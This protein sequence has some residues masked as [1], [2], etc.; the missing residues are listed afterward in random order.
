MDGVIT[1]KTSTRPL[2]A[3]VLAL[4][5]LG[6]CIES[7]RDKWVRRGARPAGAEQLRK[8]VRGNTLEGYVQELKGF[9]AYMAPDGRSSVIVSGVKDVGAWR[10]R[11]DGQLCVRYRNW[12]D[13][14]EQCA[15]YHTRDTRLR[16]FDADGKEQLG[17]RVLEGNPKDLNVEPDLV[18]ARKRGFKRMTAGEL[19]MQV[20]GNTLQGT[21]EIL[22][23]LHMLMHYGRD[24]TVLGSV[25]PQRDEGT[26]E[27]RDNGDLCATFQRW[28]DGRE[29]CGPLWVLGEE[30]AGFG[31][32]GQRVMSARLVEGDPGLR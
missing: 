10:V 25:G 2:L 23:G 26:Y 32:N 31:P 8:L 27:V 13:G 21:L 14:D 20:V 22:G 15:V 12:M 9:V 6:G 11:D 24:G 5:L 18:A 19:Q 1:A 30:Y 3:V 4:W 7:D 28:Q 16:V 29:T 17:V